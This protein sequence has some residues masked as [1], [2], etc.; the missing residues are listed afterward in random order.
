MVRFILPVL[1]AAVATP[2]VAAPMY[3]VALAAPTVNRQ[4]VRDLI[5]SCSGEACVAPLNG[6][7]SDANVCRA[8]ARKLGRVTAF[9]ADA[10]SFGADELE[11]CN[12]AAQ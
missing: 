9:S 8:V 5:W 1:A 12:T 11:K 10:R 3:R 2:A 6:T 7:T 4:V